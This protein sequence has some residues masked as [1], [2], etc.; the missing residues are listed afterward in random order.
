MNK[1][2]RCVYIKNILTSGGFVL[3]FLNVIFSTIFSIIALFIITRIIGKR[4]V[5]QLSL[6]DYVNGI[7]IGSIAAEMATAIEHD[8]F[9]PLIAM[10]IYAIFALIICIATDKSQ[11]FRAFFSGK[12]VVLF[13]EN[14][15]FYENLKKSRI[16]LNE[17]LVQMRNQGYFSLE[18]VYCAILEPNGKISILERSGAKNV[19]VNDLNLRISQQKLQTNIICDGKIMYENLKL[20]GK[21]EKWLW[22]KLKEND[23]NDVKKVFL[24][25]ADNSGNLFVYQSSKQI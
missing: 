12:S 2:L 22:S 23:I 14:K 8:M 1:N 17:F 7:T 21:N 18:D 9:K 5:S 19:S 24:A 3:D 4:Q 20:C 11:K 16:D 25:A 6:F 13:R 15:F 10:V